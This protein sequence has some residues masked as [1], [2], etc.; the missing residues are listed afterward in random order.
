MKGWSVR[1]IAFAGTIAAVYAALTIALSPISYG[2]YQIRVAEALTVLP[3]FYPPAIIALTVGCFIANIFG[4]QGLQDIIFG[5][6][7]TLLAGMLTMSAR[8]INS[9]KLSMIL[10]PL[11]PVLV[12]AFGVSLYLS[13]IVGFNYLYTVQWI[14]VGQLVACYGIGLPLLLVIAQRESVLAGKANEIQSL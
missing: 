10:A 12:N 3:Y 11:P 1:D 4:G 7:F 13:P 14:G 2:I 9:R 8:F 6:S 5:S